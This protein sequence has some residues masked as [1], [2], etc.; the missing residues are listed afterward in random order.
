V[1]QQTIK[2]RVFLSFF[3]IIVALCVCTFLLG[4]YIIQ[5]DI[6]ARARAQVNHDL[7]STRT[8]FA[9]EMK[10]IKKFFDVVDFKGDIENL[11]TS[12]GLDYL[13]IID[14]SNVDKHHSEIV[15]EAYV[16][17]SCYG[18]RIIGLEELKFMGKRCLEKSVLSIMPTPKAIPTSRQS[19]QD[20]MAI[21]HAKALYDDNNNIVGIAYGGKI[22]NRE[23]DLI[24]KVTSLVFE[25]KLYDGKPI[26]TVTIFQDDVRIATNVLDSN[27]KRAIGT[28][29][30]ETVYEQVIKKGKPW[31][32]RAFVV[33]DWYMT[34]Y[35]PI[36]NI[37]G[38]IIGILY[39]GTL[40]KP[41]NHMILEVVFVFAVISIFA[42]FLGAILSFILA[43]SICRPVESIL[44][45]TEKIS[46]GQFGAQAETRTSIIEMEKLVQSFNEM[47]EKLE[48]RGKYLQITNAKLEESNKS[49]I[50]L[51]GFVAH[52][53]KGLLSSAIMNAYS[54]RD[55]F[56]GMINFKQQRAIDSIAR[57]LDY[58]TATVKKFLNLS[59]VEKGEMD[60]NLSEIK[61]GKKVFDVSIETFIQ[62][63]NRSNIKVTNKIDRELVISADAEMM[64]IVANN[65][66]SNAAKYGKKEGKV[67]L[68]SKVDGSDVTIEVYNDARP[69][70]KE[71]IGK[72]FKK[73]SRL[74]VPEKK[75]VKGTGLGLFITKEIIEAHG[76][77]IE[78]VPR[79]NGNSFII[80]MQTGL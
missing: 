38:D 57:N 10:S 18:V 25:N 4:F 1:K 32:D 22:I 41:Y 6:L 42:V 43:G 52:E 67:E 35:E 40:E 16:D 61:I 62:Q 63:F 51:I 3:L 55:G 36:R 8:V 5:T 77:T 13:Y 17:G 79:E 31:F 33:T 69:I 11:R 80:N 65:L 47:S 44:S 27:G 76:G 20:A 48:E 70:D 66:I 58:L 68:T 34:A 53:L 15:Q 29:V 64:M 24:D 49:Y 30:S 39:V 75:T 37:K 56:L 23:F 21:E 28:R 54:L 2:Q 78:V 72:L 71:S 46:S 45:A 19:L 59:V 26:G 12:L 9:G 14:K 50:E 73:F 74:D 60:V 7:V